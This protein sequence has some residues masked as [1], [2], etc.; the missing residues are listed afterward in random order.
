MAFLCL[1]YSARYGTKSGHLTM[2]FHSSVRAERDALECG[3]LFVQLP[4]LAPWFVPRTDLSDI[5]VPDIA[6]LARK[7]VRYKGQ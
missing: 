5:G 6:R 1:A 4:S 2:R 7:R 3:R